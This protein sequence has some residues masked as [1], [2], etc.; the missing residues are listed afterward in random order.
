MGNSNLAHEM[1]E[2]RVH[3]RAHTRARPPPKQRPSECFSRAEIRRRRVEAAAELERAEN[4]AAELIGKISSETD[5]DRRAELIESAEVSTLNV[6]LL[7]SRVRFLERFENAVS[8]MPLGRCIEVDDI[9]REAERLRRRLIL[10]ARDAASD[11][12]NS[13]LRRRAFGESLLEELRRRRFNF[14]SLDAFER[15]DSRAQ[16]SK[17]GKSAWRD[18]IEDAE[19]TWADI[20]RDNGL[21]PNPA[22]PEKA[23]VLALEPALE[24]K[25]SRNEFSGTIDPD[26][27]SEV[28]RLEKA[29]IKLMR[30]SR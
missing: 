25:A 7:T 9:Q 18:E 28:E 29:A 8:R 16:A 13:Y 15:F 3:V 14:G 26:G 1:S 4:H 6:D 11:E 22:N 17:L 2:K 27:A 20:A 21:D 12:W 30:G 23:L 10:D 5:D 24:T 19:D